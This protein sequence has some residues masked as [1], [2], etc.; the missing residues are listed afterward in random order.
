M[1]IPLHLAALPSRRSIPRNLWA[2]DA[3]G[4]ERS[5][6][7][8]VVKLTLGRKRGLYGEKL[9][10]YPAYLAAIPEAPLPGSCY[11]TFQVLIQVLLNAPKRIVISLQPADHD[12]PFERCYDRR[13]YRLLVDVFTRFTAPLGVFL[14]FFL[15]A[16]AKT[17]EPS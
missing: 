17:E 11:L 10:E 14:P 2:L 13:G 16:R 4:T 6:K 3:K 8:M 12:R 9:R 5:Q 7:G 15:Y 1:P